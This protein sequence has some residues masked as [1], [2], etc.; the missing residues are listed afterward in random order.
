MPAEKSAKSRWCV[1]GDTHNL[2]ALQSLALFCK[3]V[4]ITLCKVFRVTKL[5]ILIS[6]LSLSIG[7]RSQ[8]ALAVSAPYNCGVNRRFA[9]QLRRKRESSRPHRAIGC[10]YKSLLL[11]C[12]PEPT[13][14]E[15]TEVFKAFRGFAHTQPSSQS[16]HL[17]GKAPIQPIQTS[18]PATPC[19]RYS[20]APRNRGGA[21]LS[22]CSD[23]TPSPRARDDARHPPAILE[24]SFLSPRITVPVGRMA[25]A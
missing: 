2:F 16:S 18:T 6:N 5:R 8:K 1:S 24:L 20:L 11:A 15:P 7:Y 17:P 23:I 25:V 10:K 21:N 19:S 14:N 4:R 12:P 3:H 22:Q 13:C 9:S